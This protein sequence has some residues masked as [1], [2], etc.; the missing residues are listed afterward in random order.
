MITA[1]Q[2]SCCKL[3]LPSSWQNLCLGAGSCC[4]AERRRYVYSEDVASF[5]TALWWTGFEIST[6]EFAVLRSAL[7]LLDGLETA[8][9]QVCISCLRKK[10]QITGWHQARELSYANLSSELH[11]SHHIQYCCQCR[12]V[13]NSEHATHAS[14]EVDFSEEGLRLDLLLC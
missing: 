12:Q 6:L 5:A 2:S 1:G 7:T 13:K 9:N 14:A 3:R 11:L 8:A 10:S 4:S